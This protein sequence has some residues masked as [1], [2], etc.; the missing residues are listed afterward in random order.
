MR[1]GS[2]RLRSQAQSG[3]RAGDGVDMMTPPVLRYCARSGRRDRDCL[4]ASDSCNSAAADSLQPSFYTAI[5]L[6]CRANHAAICRP[7]ARIP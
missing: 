3:L 5:V 7:C 4:S 6:C 1:A 2:A